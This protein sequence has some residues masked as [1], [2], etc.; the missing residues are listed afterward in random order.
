MFSQ[1]FSE[2]KYEI[3]ISSN[4]RIITVIERSNNVL[5][6]SLV[7]KR[8]KLSLE[9]RSSFLEVS[10]LNFNSDGVE[11]RIFV[12]FAAATASWRH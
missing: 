3:E 7:G 4:A 12:M 8:R 9:N 5:R 10:I 2:Q 6:P 1:L 11:W